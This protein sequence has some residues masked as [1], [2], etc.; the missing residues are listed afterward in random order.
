MTATSSGTSK[1]ALAFVFITVLLSMIGMGI[2]I[3]IMPDLISELTGLEKSAAA[4]YNGYLISVYALMQ[5]LMAPFLGALSDRFGRRPVLLMSLLAYSIDYMVMALAPTYALLFVGRAAAGAFA[6]T[7]ATAS[8]FIADIS[9]P[10]KRAGNFGLLGAAFGLGFIIGPA[11]GG[12]VGDFNPRYPFFLASA[13]IFANLI[14]GYFVFPETVTD[15]NRRAFDWK[16]ANPL[17]GLISVSHHKLVLGVLFCH[18]LI[19]TAHHALPATWAFF[20]S[21]KYGWSASQVGNS[22]SYVGITAAFVQG[23]LTRKLMP[24]VGEVRAVFIGGAGMI[25]ALT[26]YAFFS[27]EGWMIYAWITVGAIGGFMM[28]AM[29]AIMSRVTPPDAQGELQGAVASVMSLTMIFSPWMMTQ[30]FSAFTAR[31]GLPYLPGAPFALSALI[32]FAALIV[33]LFT[34]RSAPEKMAA[35][36]SK[37][38]A[39]S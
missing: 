34:T 37:P 17:G 39:A 27:P 14:F 26:G 16:R 22:L 23:Y 38:P 24:K 15:A 11:I 28:P 32:L 1:H 5:F 13:V 8:A 3:P 19:Q 18:F 6:A 4:K 2:V 20:T 12:W 29:Q 35:P 25:A 33:F 31:S 7:Y 10:E 9:P 21:V 36:E 30:I